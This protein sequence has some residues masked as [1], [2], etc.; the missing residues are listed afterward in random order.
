MKQC[1]T[2]ACIRSTTP[3]TQ[4][5]SASSITTPLPSSLSPG[6]LR[7]STKPAKNSWRRG[8]GQTH[9]KVPCGSGK[10]CLWLALGGLGVSGSHTHAPP[11]H[12]DMYIHGTTPRMCC[13]YCN[14]HVV[15]ACMMPQCMCLRV[16]VRACACV[17]V[18]VCV[19][20]IIHAYTDP[21]SLPLP[22][23]LPTPSLLSPS[24]PL[25]LSPSSP[26]PLP[27]PS[28]P[29]PPLSSPPYVAS[30]EVELL[31]KAMGAQFHAKVSRLMQLAH[32]TPPVADHPSPSH[33]PTHTVHQ[34]TAV[35]L[36]E[37]PSAVPLPSQ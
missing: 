3:W 24:T 28:P 6:S 4:H 8:A 31:H 20:Q 35:G 2:T 14:A 12:E 30:G 7:P 37:Q 23:P 10:E 13:M 22:L 9:K 33:C 18:C 17:H 34:D 36:Q 19:P 25:S 29:P 15:G 11:K 26:S 16:C 32:C 27:S 1:L 5:W 21:I